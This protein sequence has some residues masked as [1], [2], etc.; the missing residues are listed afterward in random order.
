MSADITNGW[1]LGCPGLVHRKVTL[2]IGNVWNGTEPF[3]PNQF[4][5][6]IS[7]NHK[8]AQGSFK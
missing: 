2:Q 5:G 6:P 4:Q 7:Q 1:S 3:Q 8:P